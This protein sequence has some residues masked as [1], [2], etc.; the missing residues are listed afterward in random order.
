MIS[1]QKHNWITLDTSG[2]K[3]NG[4]CSLLPGKQKEKLQNGLTKTDIMHTT[5]CSDMMTNIATGETI[6]ERAF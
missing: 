2:K 6:D 3:A 1:Q 4:L 5:A